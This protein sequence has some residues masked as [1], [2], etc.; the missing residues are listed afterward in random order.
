MADSIIERVLLLAAGAFRG[1]F[2][3]HAGRV[4]GQTLSGRVLVELIW[5]RAFAGV[6][7]LQEEVGIARVAGCVERPV[8]SFAVIGA[9]D[10]GMSLVVFVEIS[11]AVVYALV[12]LQVQEPFALLAVRVKTSEAFLASPIAWCADAEPAGFIWVEPI[13]TILSAQ[14]QRLRLLVVEESCVAFRAVSAGILALQ[15]VCLAEYALR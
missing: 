2:A 5:A 3:V 6:I 8:A 10:T 12:A 11:P 14:L 15:A 7:V 13:R 4:A 1:V 9:F